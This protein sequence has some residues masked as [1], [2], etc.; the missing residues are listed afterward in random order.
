MLYLNTVSLLRGRRIVELL[1]NALLENVY[2]L[3]CNRHRPE[4][5][6]FSS[7]KVIGSLLEIQSQHLSVT[8]N[9][10]DRYINSMVV[11][12]GR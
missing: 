10:I 12:R 2:R 8:S 11:E 3:H 7:V 1:I 6:K 4:S 9:K 5:R